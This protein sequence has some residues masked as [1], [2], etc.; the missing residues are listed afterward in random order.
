MGAARFRWRDR[1]IKFVKAGLRQLPHN[2]AIPILPGVP[3]GEGSEGSRGQTPKIGQ[4]LA[5]WPFSLIASVCCI[6]CLD[7]TER[8]NNCEEG[9]RQ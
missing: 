1:R 5:A 8:E 4:L 9:L 7:S 6:L 2:G 3:N